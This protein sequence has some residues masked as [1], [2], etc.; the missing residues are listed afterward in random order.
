[1]AHIRINYKNN[2][3]ATG[4]FDIHYQD[5]PDFMGVKFRR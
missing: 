3:H 4:Y 1:M 2:R 5:L